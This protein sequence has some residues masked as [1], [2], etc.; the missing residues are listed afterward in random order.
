MDLED[1]QL[2]LI[3]DTAN[4]SQLQKECTDVTQEYE[5]VSKL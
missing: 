3:L 2:L 4:V 1:R 5:G